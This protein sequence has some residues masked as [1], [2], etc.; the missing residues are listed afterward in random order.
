MNH[1][2]IQDRYARLFELPQGLSV[3]CETHG[4]CLDYRLTS[5]A[6]TPAD[7]AGH[8][9]R[10][11]IP[12]TL[13]FGWLVQAIVLLRRLRPEVLVASSDC[14]CVVLG[15]GFSRLVGARF[16]A[17]LYDEYDTFGLSK[18][19]GLRSLYRRALVRADGLVAV[20]ETLGEDLRQQYPGKPVMVLESTID[21]ALFYPRDKAA[22]RHEL[23]LD[24]FQG[25]KLVGACGGLNQFHGADIVFEAFRQITRDDPG[26][27][28]VVAGKLYDDC[29]LPESENIIY[30]GMLPHTQMPSFYSAMDVV[31]VPL[32]NTRF[33]YYAFPQKA[34]EVLAC[35]APAAAADVGALGKLFEAVPRIKYDPESSSDLARVIVAQADE[36]VL[37]E[38]DIP[39][40]ADQAVRLGAF[41]GIQASADR[42]EAYSSNTA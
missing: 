38:V 27:V 16:F 30:L 18:I 33:G 31:V 6:P 37:L 29:P 17:D 11:N 42:G 21:A 12:R 5:P 3:R 32:S 4:L 15:Y 40:W 9:R 36:H 13:F 7:L 41:I 25:K 8:W 24:K 1:D 19:P 35:R 14:L 10:I 22:S 26:I 2:V 28:C 23:G 39:T 20:S 34:Y